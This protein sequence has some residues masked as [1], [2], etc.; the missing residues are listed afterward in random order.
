MSSSQFP[1]FR[2]LQTVVKSIWDATQCKHVPTL[3]CV[4]AIKFKM[5]FVSQHGITSQFKHL[6]CFLRSNANK[7]WI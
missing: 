3:L 6:I 4:P 7:L 1:Q 5:T 2:S